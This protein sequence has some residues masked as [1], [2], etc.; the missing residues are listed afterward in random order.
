[1]DS[2][3]EAKGCGVDCPVKKTAELIEGQMNS[4]QKLK[5]NP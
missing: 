4:D 2:Y 3:K 5:N 1:M